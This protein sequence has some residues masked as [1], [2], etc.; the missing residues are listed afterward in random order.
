MSVQFDD[1]CEALLG[2]PVSLLSGSGIAEEVSNK[3]RSGERNAWLACLNPHS[4]VVALDDSRFRH[5]LKSAT[6]LVPDGAGIV[7]AS[8]WLGGKI[9]ARVTGFD[10]FDSVLEK[11]TLQR[12]GSVFFL[13]SSPEVLEK[14]GQRFSRDYPNLELAGTYSPPFKPIFD[15]EDTKAM[16][17]AVNAARPDVLWVGMTAPKQEKWLADNISNLDV[18][19]AGA[20]GAVFDFY[21]GTVTRSPKVFQQLGL[22]WLPRLLREP[23]RLWHRN[24]ISTPKFLFSVLKARWGKRFTQ[25]RN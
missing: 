2:Y 15:E 17:E 21:A 16:I 4:F 13:G 6:F 14:I 7:L 5:S 10:V 19:F 1:R 9:E 18:G 8:R 12:S 24:F 25:E 20:I 22:E 23:K 11:L 3:I